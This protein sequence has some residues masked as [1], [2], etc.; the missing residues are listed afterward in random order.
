M[1]ISFYIKL[2]IAFI[3]FAVLLL[4][5]ASFAFNNFYNVHNEKKEKENIVNIL[6]H[7]EN[8]FKNYVKFFDEKIF[9]LSQGE[10]LKIED[11]E[12]Q[13]ELFKKFLFANQNILEFSLI[14]LDAQEI[15]KVTNDSGNL[16]II[17]NEKLQNI[18]SNSYYKNIRTLKPQ[19][20]FH[21]LELETPTNVNF[22]LRDE[23]YFFLHICSLFIFKMFN[24]KCFYW[25]HF[26]F[27]NH[28]FD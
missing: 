18:Y 12:K 6:T 24:T 5:F 27:F 22:I 21:D 4:S 3:I 16:K 25:I 10:F 14:S 2:F 19:E 9:L 15:F 23:K 1:R 26:T 17:E 7:Q 28:R 8:S 13:L 20:I 11:K